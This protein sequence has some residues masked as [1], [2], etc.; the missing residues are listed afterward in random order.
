LTSRLVESVRHKLVLLFL[1]S[2]LKLLGPGF[3]SRRALCSECR[4]S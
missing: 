3:E 2:E 4:T 1:V